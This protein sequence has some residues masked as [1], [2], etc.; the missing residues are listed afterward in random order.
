MKQFL[1]DVV[2]YE[3]LLPKWNYTLIPKT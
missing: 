2:Q 3:N 1:A